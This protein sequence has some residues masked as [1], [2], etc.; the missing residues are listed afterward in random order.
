[1]KPLYSGQ[2]LVIELDNAESCAYGSEYTF[3]DESTRESKEHSLDVE[4]R[5]LVEKVERGEPIR[6]FRGA[7]EVEYISPAHI[8]RIRIKE[9]DV[10][11][12]GF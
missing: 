1:M 4:Y 11:R 6:L 5:E 8:V 3:E 12:G 7:R 9:F 10:Y 2:R